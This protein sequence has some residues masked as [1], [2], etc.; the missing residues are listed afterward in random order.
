MKGF[1]NN[2]RFFT[3]GNTPFTSKVDSFVYK[4]NYVHLVWEFFMVG[5]N[6]GKVKLMSL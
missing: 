5:L 6:R 1:F 2:A 4:N 3:V